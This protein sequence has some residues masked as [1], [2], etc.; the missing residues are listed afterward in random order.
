MKKDNEKLWQNFLQNSV[1][2]REWRDAFGAVDS[3]LNMNCKLEM[4]EHMLEIML[5]EISASKNEM[6]VTK[7]AQLMA[8]IVHRQSLN[9]KVNLFRAHTNS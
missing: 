6:L 8:R 3:L 4:D 5:M 1:L 9:A 2:I 7:M